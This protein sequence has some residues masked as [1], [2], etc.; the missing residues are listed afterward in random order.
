MFITLSEEMQLM[1]LISSQ[2]CPNL[3]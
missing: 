1:L 3:K 2:S